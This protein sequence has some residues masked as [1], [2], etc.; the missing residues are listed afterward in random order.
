M[1]Q[2]Y[3]VTQ[4]CKREKGKEKKK[5]YIPSCI[6]DLE[7]EEIAGADEVA[8]VG[9]RRLLLKRFHPGSESLPRTYTT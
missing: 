7:L 6:H 3:P 5:K 4:Q 1:T 9:K 2:W 8:I